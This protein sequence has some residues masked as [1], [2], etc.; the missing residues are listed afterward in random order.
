MRWVHLV[1]LMLPLVLVAALVAAFASPPEALPADAPADVFSAGRALAD[2]RG[3]TSSGLPHPAAHYDGSDRTPQEIADHTRAR[4]YVV[5]RLKALGLA[6]EIQTGRACGRFTCAGAENVVARID[7]E[8][9][10]PAVMLVAHYDSTPMGPG[11]ADDG[12]G[13]SSILETV[14]ALRAGPKLKRSLIVL[15]DDGEEMGLVGARLFALEH[16]WAKDVGV[17]LNFEARGTSGQAAMFETS[18]GNAGLVGIFAGAAHRPVASSVIY[19]LYKRLPNDTDLSVFKQFGMQGLNFAFADRVFDYHTPGDTADELDPR[20]LQHMGEQM[21]ATS[22]ALLAAPALP[23]AAG[24]AVYFDVLTLGI[25]RYPASVTGPLAVLG[26]LAAAF[27][28]ARAV[29]GKKTTTRR[30]LLGAAVWLGALVASTL[31]GV[32]L[33]MLLKKVRFPDLG[34][35]PLAMRAM[36]GDHH[37]FAPWLALVA[38]GA[39]AAT[40]FALWLCPRMPAA[41]GEV[42]ETA[43]AAK[44][45]GKA[46]RAADPLALAGGALVLWTVFSLLLGFAAPGASYLF[47]LVALFAAG[48]FALVA[49]DPESP[50][51]LGRGVALAVVPA[52]LLW[53]PIVRVLLIMVAGTMAPAATLPIMLMASLFTPLLAPA[54]PRMRWSIPLAAAALALVATIVACVLR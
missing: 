46:A 41:S 2:I 36:M 48:G 23:V 25:V 4:D 35:G 27:V 16:R 32:L 13:V 52:A 34:S 43:A 9:P 1:A 29:Q 24:D 8:E 20:S 39:A 22:R 10:G 7:G 53:F 54:A 40:A 45:T 30:V 11:A 17:V 50:T 6:P 33:G 19:T 37:P 44:A 42:T 14:R 18:N 31:G 28:I 5:G 12:A 15:V 47:T 51:Q 49:R 3:L 38:L 26:A 21:L